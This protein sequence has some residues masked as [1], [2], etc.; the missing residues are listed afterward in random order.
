MPV[1]GPRLLSS[2]H[3]CCPVSKDLQEIS[4][5][6][7]KFNLEL[8]FRR[9]IFDPW[10]YNH[11]DIPLSLGLQNIDTKETKPNIQLLNW[12]QSK[13]S[14]DLLC[15]PISDASD[16]H[17]GHVRYV[18]S[19]TLTRDPR[20]KPSRINSKLWAMLLY[21]QCSILTEGIPKPC[22]NHVDRTRSGLGYLERRDKKAM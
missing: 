19:A 21:H 22:S 6:C 3:N 18:R 10:F 5:I 1:L 11:L 15:W 7:P 20:F 2:T 16:R 4:D 12:I 17:T 8:Q 14:R 9:R 13:G